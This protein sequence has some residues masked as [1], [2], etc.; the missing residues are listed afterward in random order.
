MSQCDGL[1]AL[2]SHESSFCATNITFKQPRLSGRHW[3]NSGGWQTDTLLP[4]LPVSV[5]KV[6]P[7]QIIHRERGEW[8]TSKWI[9]C[10]H[11]FNKQQWRRFYLTAL[12]SLLLSCEQQQTMPALIQNGKHFSWL[13]RELLFGQWLSFIELLSECCC[14][15]AK[16]QRDASPRF[17]LAHSSL[18]SIFS[19]FWHIFVYRITFSVINPRD[20][21]LLKHLHFCVFFKLKLQA[22]HKWAVSLT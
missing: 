22:E 18:W 11:S 16:W 8:D 4:L 10:F 20:L 1:C 6:W 3:G 14:L 7:L 5:K 21:L 15:W 17:W 2:A 12:L 13:S 19:E 9:T